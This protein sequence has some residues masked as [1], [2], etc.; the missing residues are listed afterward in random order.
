MTKSSRN[1]FK[2][3]LERKWSL[4]RLDALCE[5]EKKSKYRPSSWALFMFRISLLGPLTVPGTAG[6]C[7]K[8]NLVGSAIYSCAN[9]VFCWGQGF[10]N[11]LCKIYKKRSL[12]QQIVEPLLQENIP[13]WVACVI[14]MQW[15]H[16]KYFHS[17]RFICK[18]F[19]TLFHR[20][21]QTRLL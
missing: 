6:S 21:P 18:F 5:D 13:S 8:H 17:F 7:P 16:R 3:M 11:L 10:L 15:Q 19:V 1:E 14:H 12:R 4:Y 20:M 9:Y 2:G